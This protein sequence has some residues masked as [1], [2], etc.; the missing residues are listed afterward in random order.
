LVRQICMRYEPAGVLS[1]V[2]GFQ[3]LVCSTFSMAVQV[4]W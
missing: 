4:P 2:V 3:A 1:A